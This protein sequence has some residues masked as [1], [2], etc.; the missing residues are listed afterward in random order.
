M[1]VGDLVQLLDPSGDPLPNTYGIV[2]RFTWS[3]MI[4]VH[5]QNASDSPLYSASNTWPHG[6][7]KVINESR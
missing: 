2:T 4:C 7:L 6:R 1:K 3:G 5:W